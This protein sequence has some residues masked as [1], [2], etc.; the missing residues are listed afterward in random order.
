MG[1]APGEI[2]AITQSH[3]SIPMDLDG[4]DSS[5]TVHDRMPVIAA[6][7]DCER[8]L[9]PANED[10]AD[11]ISPPSSRGWIAYLVSRR[12]N[13]PKSDDAKLIEPEAAEHLAPPRPV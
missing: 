9:D 13:D 12:V 2:I 8:W 7:K 10:I 5:A 11:L 6:S 4:A 3:R 1:R